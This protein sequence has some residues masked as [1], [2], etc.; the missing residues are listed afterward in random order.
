MYVGEQRGE[1]EVEGHVIQIC[2][3]PIFKAWFVCFLI[4]LPCLSLITPQAR[5]KENQVSPVS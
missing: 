5:I 4:R 1:A 3:L 2:T